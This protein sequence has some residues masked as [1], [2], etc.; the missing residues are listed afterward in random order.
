MS[1][2]RADAP[3]KQKRPRSRFQPL[4]DAPPR[5]DTRQ[6]TPHRRPHAIKGRLRRASR[7][8]HRCMKRV[9]LR[10]QTDVHILRRARRMTVRVPRRRRRM[11]QMKESLKSSSTRDKITSRRTP[12]SPRI[13]GARRTQLRVML[14]Q[15]WRIHGVNVKSN[16]ELSHRDHRD[17]ERQIW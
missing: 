11:P 1:D 6:T 13:P 4:S 14:R 12:M 5:C 16:I 15:R 8:N 17:R 3:G 10:A 2:S 9:M 7:R